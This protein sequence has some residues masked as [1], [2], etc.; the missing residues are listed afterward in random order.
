MGSLY[1]PEGQN[2]ERSLLVGVQTPDQTDAGSLM[3]E[4]GGLVEAAGA[5][6]VEH[7]VQ[8]RHRPDSCTYIGKGKAQEIAEL[9][10]SSDIDVVVFNNEL[11]PAQQANLTD[12]IPAKILDRT[13]VILDIF[14][15]RARSS[16]GK[17]QVE[18][19]QLNYLLP[20]L[21]GR[22]E[23]LSRLGGG[24][25]TRGPGETKLETDR[26]RIRKRI[27]DLKKEIERVRS[28]R[29]QQRQ[30]R[31][32]SRIPVVA[33]VGYT[34]AG[35]STLL[36]QLS[37]ADVYTADQLFVTLDPTIR[38]V[39]LDSTRR[40]LLCDT[41]GFIRGLPYELVA[42]FR[43]TLEEVVEAD[44][45]MHVV[46]ATDQE[47]LEHKRAVYSVLRQLRAHEKPILTVYN[48]MDQVSE[49][50]VVSRLVARTP[51]SVAVSAVTG[52]NIERLKAKTAG[53]LPGLL[54]DL[55]LH[56]PYTD[57]SIVAWLH[58]HG[59]VKREEYSQDGIDVDVTIRAEYADRVKTFA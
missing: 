25:G 48:K 9:C 3:S 46:D 11:T 44:L 36:N 50:A 12:I 20:R 35:K 47:M 59:D 6:V 34:N 42:A 13:Q 37:G 56:I 23:E 30:A 1:I 57:G 53:M 52:E 27:A 24:I 17:L 32:R 21:A 5:R 16:E 2:A 4:T 54:E 22:G 58:E 31:R 18:L 38:E 39:I 43:A 28:T 7:A 45:L 19:A 33:L 8:N 29:Y 55:T 14:A 10:E 26:R 15:Q 51:H 41:V 49:P 40:I